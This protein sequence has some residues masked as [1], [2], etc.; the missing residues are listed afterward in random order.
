M[1]KS[2]LI[3]AILFL[4]INVNSQIGLSAKAGAGFN[5]TF[6]IS[7]GENNY[8]FMLNFSPL[9]SYQAG[10]SSSI[11]INANWQVAGDILFFDKRS[12]VIEFNISPGYEISF[13]YVNMP[14]YMKFQ[15]NKKIALDFG[16]VN[17]FNFGYK[18]KDHPFPLNDYHI[19]NNIYNLGILLGIEYTVFKKAKISLVF[20]TDLTPFANELLEKE[21][22][23][24]DYSYYHYNLMLS[25][26]YMLFS[27]KKEKN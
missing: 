19:D 10:I 5:N 1:K 16:L 13:Y 7:F 23:D 17:N 22:D 14:I 20:Q 8:S 18:V 25:V 15:S 21:Y 6:R 2:I 27:T 3:I 24:T 11:S 12:E 4:T 26:S 9:V